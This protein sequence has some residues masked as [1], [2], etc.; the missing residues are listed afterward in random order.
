MKIHAILVALLAA[1]FCVSFAPAQTPSW[2]QFGNSPGGTTRNDDIYFADLTNGWSAR[3]TDGVYRTTNGGSTWIKVIP[4]LSPVA[5]F[6]CIG[7]ASALRG[8]AGNL[9]P[10]SYDNTV[11][12][13][14]MLYETFDGGTNWSVA[15]DINA[16]GMQG[17]CALH[18]KDAQHIYGAGRVRGPAYFAKSENG[19]ASWWVT[20]LT[21]A[22]V[23]GGLMDVYFRDADNGFIVGMDTNAYN[24]VCTTPSYHGAIA[25]TTNGGLSWQV[26]ASTPVNCSYFWKM[27]WP[28]AN[29]GYATLQQNGTNST[30][31]FYKTTDGGATWSSNGIPHTTIGVSAAQTWFLQGVGFV[32]VSEGWMGGSVS[33]ALT[34]N[35][36]FIHTT[37]GGLT[38][39]PVGYD[40]TRG[41]NRIR[42]ISPT[43][44]YGSGQKL[45][46]FRVPLAI[47]AQP[48][49]ST[50]AAGASATFNVTAY[51]T[52]PLAYQW[53]LG[54]TNIAGANANSYSVLNVQPTNA[55]NYNVVVSDYS[56]SLTSAV[57]ALTVTGVPLPPSVVTQPQSHVVNP[58]DATDFQV[59]VTGTPPLGFQWRL[60]GANLSG[61]A[62]NTSFQSTLNIASVQPTNAGVYSVVISNSL[63]SVISA[64]ATLTIGYADNFETR[65]LSVTTSAMSTN[66]YRIFWTATN[67]PADFRAII[68]YDYSAV[69]YPTNIP[70]APNSAPGTTK[71]LLLAVNKDATPGAAAVNLY[72][73]NF[74]I[75]GDYSFKFDLWLNWVVAAGSTEHALF[76]INHSGA[77]TN[78]IGKTGSDGLFFA[79]DGD[80]GSSATSGAVRDY[81]VFRGGGPGAA[82]LM[83]TTNNTEFGP[84]P[85]LAPQFDNANPGFVSLFPARTIPGYGTTPTG[86]A[87]L[88]WVRGEVR[89]KYDRI[90][91]LL[92]DTIVAQC[93]NSPA[94]TNGTILIGLSDF[95]ESTGHTNNFVIFDNLRVESIPPASITLQSPQILG[96]TFSFS[97][98]TE[99]YESYTVQ[100]A[101]NLAP[102]A[103]LSY[104]N[105]LGSGTVTNVIVPWMNTSTETYFRVRQP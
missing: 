49:N 53:R 33:T 78:Q 76:G 95:F 73:T 9:G 57:A 88:G 48:T 1:P 81:S 27:S 91:W 105:L 86:S 66:G 34:F 21:A 90:T 96:G 103:W 50:A 87:G 7:F 89:Q 60:N 67:G 40:N 19:G 59:V 101:T 56:G 47:T 102:P 85:L 17:F 44:G 93:T 52:A 43:L 4:N 71:G 42:F 58:G 6:R 70:S 79:M 92:N 74:V 8:W 51:G 32:S 80:G 11:T 63:G 13:T 38:W 37:D 55:G 84:A 46:V 54:G 64:G 29:T 26:V 99:P 94:Y 104:T 2:S 10:G 62:S 98:A 12:D 24:T 30:I 68:G 31:I 97:F 16:S 39:N 83:L 75:S 28:S 20:N 35:Q 77:V 23:M 15:P 41:M 82:P 22:G 45:H 3:A 100:W 65:A 5:H 72:P 69:T 14:N 25:R 18:V 61:G 36:C